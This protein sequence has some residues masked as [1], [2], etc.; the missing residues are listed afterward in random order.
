MTSTDELRGVG[1][2]SNDSDDKKDDDDEDPLEMTRPL[3]TTV[4]R[5]GRMERRL[6]ETNQ[7]TNK[8]HVEKTHTEGGG[9]EGEKRKGRVWKNDLCVQGVAGFGC[10]PLSHQRAGVVQLLGARGRKLHDRQD[11]FFENEGMGK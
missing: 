5:V 7:Q 6:E 4:V 2:T 10:Y 11:E 3:A 1:T 8:Q 9:R